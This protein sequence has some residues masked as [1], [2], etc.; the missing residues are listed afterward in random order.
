LLVTIG[1]ASCVIGGLTITKMYNPNKKQEMNLQPEPCM[2][3]IGIKSF[4]GIEAISI[5]DD[6][7]F[8]KL[9][10]PD[11]VMIKVRASAIDPIDFKIITGYNTKNGQHFTTPEKNLDGEFPLTLG[12]DCTGVIVAL[13]EDATEFKLGDEVWVICPMGHQGY[14]RDYIV[15]SK[16][17]VDHK[18]K[19]LTFEEAAAIP[20]SGAIVWNA[21]IRQAKLGPTN[22]ASKRVLIHDGSSEIGLLAIQLVK[23][24]GG[25]VTTT[26]TRAMIPKAI[27][28]GVN[29]IIVHDIDDF[30][31]ELL[32]RKKFHV[33]LN[34][35]GTILHDQCK[36]ICEPDGIILSL[37]S[38]PSAAQKY[39]IFPGIFHSVFT[40]LKNLLTQKIIKGNNIWWSNTNMTADSLTELRRLIEFGKIV[41]TVDSIWDM[42]DY[43]KAF[44]HATKSPPCGKVV[45]R[46]EESS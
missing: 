15:V 34:T 37:V 21:L 13:G 25:H 31:K 10:K 45:I 9:K 5:L 18:P 4:Q 22:T 43:S 17:Y 26:V 33:I 44:Q 39:G 38:G 41:P 12:R 36:E 20:Y 8:P 32:K 11:E 27:N 19:N 2:K 40:Y 29:D 28:M 14:M 7:P 46:M 23:I 30:A 35:V 16:D 24:W 6:L 42:C 3:G 1:T